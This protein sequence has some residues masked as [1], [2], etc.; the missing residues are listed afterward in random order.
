MSNIDKEHSDATGRSVK[1]YNHFWVDYK[2]KHTPTLWSSSS[3]PRY[4]CNR[5]E[6]MCLQKDLYKKVCRNFVSESQNMDRT[7]VSIKGR[8]VKTIIAYSYNGKFFCQEKE[9]ITD[10]LRQRQWISKTLCW[11]KEF[12]RPQDIFCAH[13]F[14]WSFRRGKISLSGTK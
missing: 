11:V 1:W 13:S 4:L 7:Q 14:I 10:A 5:N 9:Q 3:A 8:M 6:N 2:T 12:S